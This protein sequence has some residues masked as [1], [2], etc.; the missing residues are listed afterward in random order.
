MRLARGGD[1]RRDPDT[2]PRLF[3]FYTRKDYSPGNSC[4]NDFCPNGFAYAP[5]ANH[6]LHGAVSPVSQ[7]GGVQYDLLMG[8]TLTGGR[9]WFHVGGTWIGSYPATL[10][11]NGTLGTSARLASFGGETT[12]GFGVFPAMGSGRFPTEGYG[13]AAYQRLAAVNDMSGVLRHATLTAGQVSPACYD[14]SISNNTAGGWGTYFYYGGPG[15]LNC[16]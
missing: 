6:V 13:R 3:V 10:F 1:R 14:V 8:F 4:Y 5:G 9:W 2:V 12:T 7:Q 15:G 11:A 16:P